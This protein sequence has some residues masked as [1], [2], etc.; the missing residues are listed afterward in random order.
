MPALPGQPV[1]A[2]WQSATLD[3]ATGEPLVV[4]PW[5]TAVRSTATQPGIASDGRNG[6]RFMIMIDRALAQNIAID[7]VAVLYRM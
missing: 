5:R 1:R 4:R 2:L 3:L 6:F 7:S